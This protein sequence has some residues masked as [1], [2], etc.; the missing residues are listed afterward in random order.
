MK[1]KDHLAAAF[2]AGCAEGRLLLQKCDMHGH[3]Q[4]PPGPLCR[5]CGGVVQQ[6]VESARDGTVEAFSLVQ[7]APMPAFDAYVPYM[8]A[9]VKLGEGPI[10]ET[11]LRRDGRT[12]E[13]GE[14][15]IGQAVRFGF[16]TVDGQPVPVASLV[17]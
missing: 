6:W 12:P 15:S 11:W 2:F 7:R 14:V 5:R 17:D 3:L 1:S 13:L 9:V 16:E 4:Y 8:V 10:V